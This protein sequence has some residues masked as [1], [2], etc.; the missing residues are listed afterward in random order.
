VTGA[1]VAVEGAT[2]ALRACA[3]AVRARPDAGAV[4]RAVHMARRR[5]TRELTI[6]ARAAVARPV[7]ALGLTLRVIA[8]AVDI[9]GRSFAFKR[10][11]GSGS[12]DAAPVDTWRGA[13]VQ[14]RRE[15][16]EESERDAYVDSFLK[17][18]G[19]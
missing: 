4:L 11:G 13:A 7:R 15:A 9:A 6:A 10:A 1:G 17:A 19:V 5:L 8:L 3:I 16:A 2:A 14:E 18:H 12:A